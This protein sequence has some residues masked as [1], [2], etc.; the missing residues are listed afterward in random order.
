MEQSF[1]IK[2]DVRSKVKPKVNVRKMLMYYDKKLKPL[3]IGIS[4]SEIV[5]VKHVK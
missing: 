3:V 1:F 4:R 2:G 5:C